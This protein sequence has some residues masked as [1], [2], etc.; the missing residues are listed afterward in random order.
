MTDTITLP[1]SVVEQAKEAMEQAGKQRGSTAAEY[2]SICE[3]Q[4]ALEK[5]PKV[6]LPEEFFEWWDM[7]RS[8]TFFQARLI[9]GENQ[10]EKRNDCD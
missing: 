4:K 7:N 3:L 9:L 2:D 1:R 5:P 10:R 6:G 8:L